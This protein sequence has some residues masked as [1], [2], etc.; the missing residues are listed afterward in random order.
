MD[1]NA[2]IDLINS[3]KCPPYQIRAYKPLGV[4]FVTVECRI[5]VPDVDT[6][7]VGPLIV[8]KPISFPA[9]EAVDSKF[10]VESIFGY[11]KDLAIHELREWFSVA[12]DKVYYPHERAGRRTI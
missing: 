4:G 7:I 10:I 8:R 12:G 9:V 11:L 6:G 2:A 3:I 1:I 5:D